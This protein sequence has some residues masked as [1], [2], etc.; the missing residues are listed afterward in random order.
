MSPALAIKKCASKYLYIYLLIFFFM[1]FLSLYFH[2]AKNATP[3]A[4]VI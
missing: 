2:K 4:L 3:N 1:S